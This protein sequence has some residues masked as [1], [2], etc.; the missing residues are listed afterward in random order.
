MIPTGKNSTEKL[1][2]AE[3]EERQPEWC[4]SDLGATNE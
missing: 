1:A 4:T 3:T 2:D